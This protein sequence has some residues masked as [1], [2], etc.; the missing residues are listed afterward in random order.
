MNNARLNRHRSQRDTI[1][2][3]LLWANAR[4]GPSVQWNKRCAIPTSNH[5]FCQSFLNLYE[6]CVNWFIIKQ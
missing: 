6:S 2:W 5:S 3:A 4:L 1:D